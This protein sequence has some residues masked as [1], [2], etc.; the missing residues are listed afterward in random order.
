MTDKNVEVTDGPLFCKPCKILESNNLL[1]VHINMSE[2]GVNPISSASAI[3]VVEPSKQE[4]SFFTKAI[5]TAGPWVG[6]ISAL[7]VIYKYMNDRRDARTAKIIERYEKHIAEFYGPMKALREESKILYDIFALE[8]K[9]QFEDQ[10]EGQRFRTLRHLREHQPNTLPNYDQEILKQIITISQKNIE[11]IEKHGGIIDSSALSSLL[12]KLCAH[13]K[14][15]Q[16]AADGNAVGAPKKLEEIVF[17]LETDGAIDNEVKKIDQKLRKLRKAVPFGVRVKKLRNSLMPNRTISFY[18]NNSDRYYRDTNHVDM[19][20]SYKKFREN[21]VLGGRIL[22]A[23]CGVGRDTRFFIS[24]GYKVQS[25]DLSA[26]MCKITRKYPFAFCQQ[27]SFKDV[28]YHEEYDGIWANA[29]LLH[30]PPRD[31][32]DV[33]GRLA[34]ALKINGALFASFKT[35]RNFTSKDIRKFYFHTK[36]DLARYIDESGYNLELI[37]SW[38]SHKNG[39]EQDEEFESYIWV[40][41]S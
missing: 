38:S 3:T 33:I 36:D 13:F 32:V 27:M 10:N 12:G 20:E 15:M 6:L 18:D 40:R 25:F 35:S 23:G 30:V 4:P 11:F 2:F 8:A 34:R 19:S 24:K 14:V 29:S 41:G 28:D 22:D 16:I 21:I 31:M 17:P 26:E 39:D 7:F 37:D 5:E 1:E 9:T